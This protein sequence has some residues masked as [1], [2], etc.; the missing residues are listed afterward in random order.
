MLFRPGAA[1]EQYKRPQKVYD[2]KTRLLLGMKGRYKRVSGPCSHSTSGNPSN[3]EDL[4]EVDG[5]SVR[6]Y[7]EFQ[8]TLRCN[9]LLE[10]ENIN[11]A[12]QFLA[13]NPP[14]LPRTST[15]T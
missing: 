8:E 15:A 1:C 11:N 2:F 10:K 3:N 12:S 6:L 5:L 4:S 14:P 13:P 9:N 7:V